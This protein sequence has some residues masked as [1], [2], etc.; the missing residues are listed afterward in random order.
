MALGPS[1]V[2]LGHHVGDLHPRPIIGTDYR[3]A[4]GD[5][6]LVSSDILLPW[7]GRLGVVP[8][9]LGLEVGK[10]ER[11]RGAYF[12]V[13]GVGVGAIG[14]D[15]GWVDGDDSVDVVPTAVAAWVCALIAGG[16]DRGEG[17]VDGRRD[18]GVSIDDG[19][20]GSVAGGR[21]GDGASVLQTE[22]AGGGRHGP[23]EDGGRAGEV[24]AV[25]AGVGFG[26]VAAGGG[27][28]VGGD[29]AVCVAGDG[30]CHGLVP[31]APEA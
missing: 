20:V 19:G 8:D 25:C 12:W 7:D 2:D 3:A 15:A 31:G 17:D 22:V 24:V 1:R 13:L 26:V 14:G 10:V 16:V 30:G 21:G 28:G 5:R 4:S 23:V 27:A 6:T 18:E 11:I 29:R 9:G